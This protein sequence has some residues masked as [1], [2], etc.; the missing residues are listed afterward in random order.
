MQRHSVPAM[1]SRICASVGFGFL[2]S[3]ALAVM[4]WPFWQKPHCGTCSSI[5]ACCSGCSLPSLASPSSV[6]ISRLARADSR[7]DAR[8]HRLAVDDH[9]AGAALA[10]SAAEPRALQAE[11]V[12]QDIEQRRRRLDVHGVRAAVHLQCDGA[13]SL[14]SLR[15]ESV[16]S[17]QSRRTTPRGHRDCKPVRPLPVFYV[18]RWKSRGKNTGGRTARRQSGIQ[19]A[20]R[21]QRQSEPPG[22]PPPPPGAP[23][24]AAGREFQRRVIYNV[25]VCSASLER[26][27]RFPILNSQ[28]SIPNC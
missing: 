18:R 19:A 23:R 21:R 16:A 11:I 2:S 9:G 25:R 26:D 6:V 27:C 20:M 15:I 7:R 13:H 24:P 28:L 1:P 12:A 17:R 5:H 14:L 10:E 3:S 8:P 22:R 4:I